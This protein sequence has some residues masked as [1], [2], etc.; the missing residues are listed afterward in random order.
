MRVKII[1]GPCFHVLCDVQSAP[2]CQ[3]ELT[4]E[5]INTGGVTTLRDIGLTIV[6]DIVTFN[7]QLLMSNRRYRVRVS[8]SNVGNSALS[9]LLISKLA[10]FLVKLLF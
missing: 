8:A 1:N 2:V 7:S 10:V 5:D 6:R 3:A 9:E 4:F